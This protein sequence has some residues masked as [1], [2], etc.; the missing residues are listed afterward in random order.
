MPAKTQKNFILKCE[1][2]DGMFSDE[3]SIVVHDLGG[4]ARSFFVPKNQTTSEGVIVL[5][6]QPGK[7]G[8]LVRL[9]V[10]EPDAMVFARKEDLVSGSFE[11]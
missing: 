11:R 8:V 6:A 9:P 4:L 2:R 7:K 3:A 5:S 10:A 1:V